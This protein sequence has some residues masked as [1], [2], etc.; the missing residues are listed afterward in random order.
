VAAS[1]SIGEVPIEVEAKLHA[2][3]PA[4]HAL[5][6]ATTIAGWQIVEQREVRLRDTYWDTPDDRL[7]R[8]NC[9][10]RVRELDGARQA[11]LT[12]KGPVAGAGD[13]GPAHSRTELTVA[14][15]AGSGPA[16]WADLPSAGPIW[17][18]LQEVVATQLLRP[19]V[20]LLNPRRDLVLRQG[21]AEVVL[22]L[23]EV[24]IEGHPYVRRYVEVELV[25]GP[26][27][28]FDQ[29]VH[30]VAEQ[31]RLRPASVPKVQ[32]ARTWLARHSRS[33]K[34][35][36]QRQTGPAHRLHSTP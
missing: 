13:R 9:T 10:L 8:A 19:D 16:D 33:A 17:R 11:E 7:G 14:A 22:S 1:S 20:V 29:L 30:A 4:F 28:P 2:S 32:A 35:D 3:K 24:R 5:A 27:R 21:S 36:A 6:R 31:Y 26:R 25:R 15:P 18:A 12:F 34:H 23:D